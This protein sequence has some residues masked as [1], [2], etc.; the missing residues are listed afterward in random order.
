MT[1]A[2][3][4]GLAPQRETAAD[5]RAMPD[6]TDIAQYAADKEGVC[7]RVVPMRAFDPNTSRTSYIGAPCKATVATTCPACAKANKYL[8]ITQLREG[9]CA[10]H[11]PADSEPVVT[12]A[13]QAVFGARATLFNQYKDARADGDDGLAESI[14]ALVA[15]LDTE[16]RDLGVRGRLAALDEKPRRKTKSTRRRDGLPDLPRLKVDKALTIGKA[17]ADGK[18]RPS[19]FFTLTL[20]SFG[21]INKVHDSAKNE[22]VS[23]GSPRDPDSYDYTRQARDTIH[24]ARLFSKWIENLRRA[25]GWNVQYFATVEPQRRGAPHLHV[26][27]RGSFSKKLLYQVTAATYV[28][29][30][31][32]HFDKPVYG[33]GRMPV[34]DY[35]AG[36]FAD[37][38]TGRPLT[39]WDD[40]LAVMD[41]VDELDPAHTLKFGG[42]S[43]AQQIIAGTE[44]MDYGVRYLTK[45]LTKSL[46]E[47]LNPGSRRV[48][49]HYDR[50][51]AELCVTPCSSRC[52]VWLL[53]GIVPK[54]ASEKTQPGK[55]KAN[56]HRRDTLG[57]PGRRV[58]VSGKWTGK[59]VPDH[60]AERMEFVRQQLAAVGI[61]PPDTS[62]LR[63]TPVR[64]GDKDAPPKAQLVMNLVTRKINERAQYTMA[65]LAQ[66]EGPPGVSRETV[67]SQQHSYVWSSAAA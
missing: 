67:V 21:R 59:T 40:A 43:D 53:Y 63:I 27:L 4:I 48:A 18:Y 24:T 56:A 61:Y 32:P 41:E 60:K 35:S 30:W 25:V 62:H 44:G 5:R 45:Y 36:T 6:L 20:D 3:I 26:A 64:P 11:E 14:K 54:G 50:L 47:L 58:L 23:D 55:C 42:Q 2:P 49:E 22:M 15:E 66:D 37:P 10:E 65:R 13:Q 8:R 7:A 52:G 28:N 9:W 12:E 51:H 29:I 38:R 46:G 1:T 17:Y 19:T 16:L 57:L 31:W 39:Y 34:W 33:E